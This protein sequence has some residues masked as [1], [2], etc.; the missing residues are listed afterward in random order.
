MRI[1]RIPVGI[2]IWGLVALIAL[3]GM[4]YI[5]FS[6]G[7]TEARVLGKRE[8]IVPDATRG[9][10]LRRPE[11]LVFYNVDNRTYQDWIRLDTATYDA[12]A[13]GD[14]VDV[15][16]VL[17]NPVWARHA[18]QSTLGSLVQNYA[19]WQ[20]FTWLVLLTGIGFAIAMHVVW[21]IDRWWMLRRSP[22]RRAG[23]FAAV[24]LW[25]AIVTSGY[26]PPP[27]PGMDD[28]L[29]YGTAE[30]RIRAV[31]TINRF[32]GGDSN[33]GDALLLPLPQGLERIELSFV[34]DNWN[35]PV[36]AVDEVDEGSA[37]PLGVG[38]TV[39][40]SYAPDHPRDARLETGT[41]SHRWQNPLVIQ[42]T[43]LGIVVL[44]LA[45]PLAWRWYRGGPTEPIVRRRRW[46]K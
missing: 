24:L 45:T 34:P 29:R 38:M 22:A 31:T 44:A 42:T 10:W 37:G 8:R 30:A 12:T 2:L 40:I 13:R 5:E 14:T 6:R 39:P 1:G 23:L 43:V 7:V 33:T 25:V 28:T 19:P 21:R 41:R 17:L 35:D 26:I 36:I 9:S 18:S 27:W 20:M 4:F 16:Y 15:S 11:V 3:S 32:G 46:R